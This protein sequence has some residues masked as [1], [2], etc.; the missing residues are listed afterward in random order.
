MSYRLH[1][2]SAHTNQFPTSEKVAIIALKIECEES[3]PHRSAQQLSLCTIGKSA[4]TDGSWTNSFSIH[5][6]TLPKQPRLVKLIC[7]RTLCH[8]AETYH[9]SQ[10][11]G[12]TMYRIYTI[13]AEVFPSTQFKHP[14][15]HSQITWAEYILKVTPAYCAADQQLKCILLPCELCIWIVLF[16]NKTNK[17]QKT[18]QAVSV[19]MYMA[20][21]KYL[22]HRCN[23]FQWLLMS[24]WLHH[25]IIQSIM[26][27]SIFL[28]KVYHSQ[29][30][31][32]GLLPS[33]WAVA[34]WNVESQGLE[35]NASQSKLTINFILACKPKSLEFFN[36]PDQ[37]H[38][39]S[40]LITQKGRRSLLNKDIS[41]LSRLAA[42][43]GSGNVFAPSFSF[44]PMIN[45]QPDIK[46]EVTILRV[47]ILFLLS[48]FWF[49]SNDCCT[50]ESSD[51]N[52]FKEDQMASRTSKLE[53][54]QFGSECVK[55]LPMCILCQD[56]D[57][58]H[59]KKQLTRKAVSARCIQS[60]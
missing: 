20:L 11:F 17:H 46:V 22:L 29:S 55:V 38:F 32:K 35:H 39:L 41:L 40:L 43:I 3:N 51:W 34:V 16:A 23:K 21:R 1:Q 5:W 12:T 9:T 7:L 19:R 13:T 2:P 8:H 18:R 48:P 56:W 31:M 15:C 33:I 25:S 58:L 24:T 53:P 60:T 54:F 28:W 37:T 45:Q 6:R 4:A 30:A 36:A 47:L 50:N 26:K 44:F 27:P 42:A 14:D 49:C 52:L 57:S 10:I 59:S